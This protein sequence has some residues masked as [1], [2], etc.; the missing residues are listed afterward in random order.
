MTKLKEWI[1]R[2]LSEWRERARE[3]RDLSRMTARDFGDIAV[4]PALIAYERRRWPWRRWSD[5]WSAIGVSG[6]E[7]AADRES[8]ERYY[9]ALWGAPRTRRRGES[10]AETADPRLAG[11]FE[12]AAGHAGR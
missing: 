11:R 2:R 3:R 4:A 5:A 7:E 1:V 9:D 6:R 10:G 8:T 12:S